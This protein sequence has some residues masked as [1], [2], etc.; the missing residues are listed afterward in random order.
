MHQ[1]KIHFFDSP[2][3]SNFVYFEGFP[4]MYSK[5]NL[6]N[7]FEENFYQG[8]KLH[9]IYFSLTDQNMT[10]VIISFSVYLPFIHER[11]TLSDEPLWYL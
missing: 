9:I 3:S 11:E 6:K 5:E 8:I 7:V 1:T 2:G 10:T 4:F